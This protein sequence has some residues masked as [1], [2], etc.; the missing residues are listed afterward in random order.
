M[1][2]QRQKVT[3][4]Y[5]IDGSILLYRPAARIQSKAE[6]LQPRI[7]P[8]WSAVFAVPL[9]LRALVRLVFACA[10]RHRSPPITPRESIP[11]NVQGSRGLFGREPYVTC[12]DCGKKFVYNTKTRRMVDF[13]GVHDAEAMAGM[14]GK[15][16]NF[17]SPL[18][19]LVAEV[20]SLKRKILMS[21]QVR[22]KGRPA[23]SGLR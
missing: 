18:G 20:G 14:R 4:A 17:F 2:P 3:R 1:Q 9:F 8:W 10:H 11:S 21:G 13:W 7:G 22:S 16:R 12:L 5:R 19:G 23:S 6:R 15:V